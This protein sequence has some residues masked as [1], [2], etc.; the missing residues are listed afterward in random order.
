MGKD[1]DGD[2]D[3][4]GKP[5]AKKPAAQPTKTTESQR[6]GG[7][8]DAGIDF[9]ALMSQGQMLLNKSGALK[10]TKEGGLMGMLGGFTGMPTEVIFYVFNSN[11]LNSRGFGVVF[12]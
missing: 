2:G 10:P 5:V 3:I 9:G 11:L 8:G 4:G 6:A 12:Q 1:L 7:E